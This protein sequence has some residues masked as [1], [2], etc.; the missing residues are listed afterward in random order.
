MFG[1][2]SLLTMEGMKFPKLHL[3]FPL[4]KEGELPFLC[5]GKMNRNSEIL[6]EK[7]EELQLCSPLQELPVLRDGVLVYL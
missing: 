1:G 3:P 2:S 4:R 5:R 7:K 6:S